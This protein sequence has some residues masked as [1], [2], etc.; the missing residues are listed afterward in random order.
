MSSSFKNC[1]DGVLCRT[2]AAVALFAFMS[3]SGLADTWYF[4]K[5]STTWQHW[6]NQYYYVDAEGVLKNGCKNPDPLSADDDY[7]L[8][9]NFG[10]HC[11]GTFTGKSLT[12][13][14]VNGDYGILTLRGNTTFPVSSSFVCLANGYLTR[15]GNGG[16]NF[17]G[18]I[19]IASPESKPFGVRATKTGAITNIGSEP[20]SVSSEKE[21]ALLVGMTSLEG[22]VFAGRSASVAFR[23]DYSKYYGTV[24]VTSQ[25][26]NVT[27]SKFYGSGFQ[28]GGTVTD[29]FPGTIKIC[30]GGGLVLGKNVTVGAMRFDEGST[31]RTTVDF[32]KKTCHAVTVTDSLTVNGKVSVT[33][34]FEMKSNPAKFSMPLI[35]G[36]KGC[37]ID[38]SKFEFIP[39]VAGLA[40]D[41]CP[42]L[43]HL[44]VE[45][46]EDVDTLCIV[47][48]PLV[49]LKKA[50]SG[51]PDI[52]TVCND[53]AYWS[54]GLPVHS[55]ANYDFHI[56]S[57]LTESWDCGGARS[58]IFRGGGSIQIDESNISLTV[59]CIYWTGT[60]S[61]YTGKNNVAVDGGRIFM[62]DAYSAVI[63]WN[64]NDK[65][66]FTIGSELVGTGILRV[67]SWDERGDRSGWVVLGSKNKDY[68]GGF[69]VAGVG[70]NL[71][72]SNN[73]VNLCISDSDNLGG[74]L[75]SLNFRA[76]ELKNYG[77]LYSEA[78][79]VLDSERNRGV[80]VNTNGCIAAAE[81][82]TLDIEWP[83]T[84]YGSLWLTG[85]GAVKLS[86]P[87]RFYDADTGSSVDDPG[88]EAAFVEVHGASL[89]VG[90]A[91]CCD[92]ATVSVWPDGEI[93]LPIDPE[94]ADV[95]KWGLR[96]VKTDVPFALAGGAESIKVRFEGDA[97]MPY[98]EVRTNAVCTVK[99]SAAN[100]VL[101]MLSNVKPYGA[102]AKCVSVPDGKGEATIYS[103]SIR[104]ALTISIR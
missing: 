18:H 30:G 89:K 10:M 62:D 83:I 48:E 26:D 72:P 53:G 61:L 24:I 104:K 102:L 82:K 3:F 103:V 14:E 78:D 85:K 25:Y 15:D 69:L 63:V 31:I 28:L 101:A 5:N 50:G 64:G 45:T 17:N 56:K 32:S 16:Y 94:D 12:I 13:G 47:V 57:Y 27:S 100:G 70:S 4:K 49:S 84:M 9:N 7:V 73:V 67:T 22:G 38:P 71:T 33:A 92:G 11:S 43:V 81:G 68:S 1:G 41:D 90:S 97:V 91:A 21:T 87:M 59:P 54:D 79:V 74:T 55:D 8:R 39:K 40:N 99:E 6:T 42:Q 98:G 58:V 34:S 93:V 51:S 35:A 76:V 37:R 46:A 66:R 60:Y 44:A 75:D 36:P 77:R 96:N 2:I 80:F 20:G 65:R 29:H 86:G 23:G 52:T 88:A 19:K 95:R